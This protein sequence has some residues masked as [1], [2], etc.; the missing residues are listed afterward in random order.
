MTDKYHPSESSHKKITSNVAKDFFASFP[1]GVTIVTSSNLNG[2]LQGTTV[3]AF[4]SVSLEPTLILIC[5][6]QKSRTATAISERKSFAVH[7]LNAEMSDL[8]TH[9]A[10]NLDH[11]FSDISYKLSNK[12]IPIIKDC[13][14][15]IECDLQAS[16]FEGDHIIMIGSVT[17][18]ESSSDFE[19]LVYHQRLFH[20]LRQVDQ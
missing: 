14:T 6:D 8:A 20:S 2:A 10:Q 15:Y 7:F 16:H 19:P 5:L 11:K 12:N 17:K 9:F 3:S 1:S 13:S 4:T 18:I